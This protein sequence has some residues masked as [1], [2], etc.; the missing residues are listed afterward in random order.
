MAPVRV[1]D[2]STEAEEGDDDE[3]SL[4]S[5]AEGEE[6]QPISFLIDSMLGR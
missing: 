2:S 4:E 6:S 5:A 1:G 3:L